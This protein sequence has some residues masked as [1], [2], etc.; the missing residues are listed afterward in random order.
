MMINPPFLQADDCVYLISP[1]GAIDSDIVDSAEACLISWGLRVVRGKNVSNQNGRFSGNIQER[2]ID[3]QQALDDENCKAIFCT[4]GGYGSVHLLD[5]IVLDGFRKN[6]KWLIG[7]SDITMFHARL[8]MEG[9]ASIHGG[10]AKILAFEFDQPYAQIHLEPVTLLHE[11]LWGKLPAY[12]TLEHSLNRPGKS[13]GILCGGNLSIL[14][15]LRGT[16]YDQI[17]KDSILFIEDIGE[18][19]Y[20][21]DRIM[22]NLKFGGILEHISGLI[23]GQFSEFEEDPSF[24]QSVYEIIADAVS[25]YSYPVCFDFPV[26]HTHNNLPLITGSTVSFMVNE[27]GSTLSYQ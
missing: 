15:S 24:G 11:M 8:K 7:Y 22:H 26:G 27:K 12:E 5:K 20:V 16:P 17:P 18:K 23:V 13:T 14:Y 2:L 9:Y 4:R 6:P 25:D 3:L 10:M 21:I 19:P 1:A